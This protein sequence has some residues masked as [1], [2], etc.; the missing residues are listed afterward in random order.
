MI[1]EDPLHEVLPQ[2]RI[3]EASLFFHR[4]VRTATEKGRHTDRR[5]GAKISPFPRK[6]FRLVTLREI[7]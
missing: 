5:F 3:G 2:A 1:G 6:G 7:G 4:K